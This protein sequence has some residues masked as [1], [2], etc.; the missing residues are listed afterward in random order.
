MANE[1]STL[2][3]T[4]PDDSDIAV[5]LANTNGDTFNGNIMTGIQDLARKLRWGI[6]NASEVS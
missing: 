6:L 1:Y 2:I 4:K 5:I 3:P